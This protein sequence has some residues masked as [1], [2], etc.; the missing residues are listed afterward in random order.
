M[1]VPRLVPVPAL[2]A[3]LHAAQVLA[4]DG[5]T[6]LYVVTETPE[7]RGFRITAVDAERQTLRWQRRR[8]VDSMGRRALRLL[9]VADNQE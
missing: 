7:G 8:V 4:D 9:R 3:P 1:S 5:G 6:V 2:G